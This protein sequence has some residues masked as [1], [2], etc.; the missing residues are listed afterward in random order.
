TVKWLENYH[1]TGSIRGYREGE[2]Y[3]PN[4]PILQVRGSFGECTLL[5]TLILS[6]LN[7]YSAVAAAA[8][9]MVTAAKN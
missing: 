2:V 8:S 7:Y 4:S 1:F 3:I 5:E 6:I 9:R